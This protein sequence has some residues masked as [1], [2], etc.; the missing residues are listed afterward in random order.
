MK[1][2]LTVLLFAASVL[3]GYAMAPAQAPCSSGCIGSWSGVSGAA[4]GGCGLVLVWMS[5]SVPNGACESDGAGGC[6]IIADCE[7]SARLWGKSSCIASGSYTCGTN[8]PVN[9]GPAMYPTLVPLSP[10]LGPAPLLCGTDF[11]CTATASTSSPFEYRYE[12][13]TVSCSACL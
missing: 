3:L 4:G 7:A 10:T 11:V 13:L 8:P 2:M 5:I 1:H 6:N 9:F 12:Q